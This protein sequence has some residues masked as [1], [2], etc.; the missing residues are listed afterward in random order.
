[1]PIAVKQIN[2][3]ELATFVNS[4]FS[5]Q[6]FSG[7]MLDYVN[8][9]GYLGPHVVYLTGGAQ[10]IF[11]DIVF[12]FSP[13]VP[14]SGETGE[15]VARKYVDDLVN[16]KINDFSGYSTGAFVRA[17]F[18]NTFTA[19][20][21][22]T[23]NIFIPLATN[24]GH[25]ANLQNIL[26]AS[27]VLQSGIDNI[28]IAGTVYEYGTQH[29]TGQKIFDI[30]PLVVIP[31]NPSGA[32]PLS[33]LSG[34]QA[35]N[36]LLLT[37]DQTVSGIKTFLQSPI[38]PIGVDPNSAVR[39][40]QLDALGISMGAI[41]GFAGV[42]SLNG[43]SG[44]SGHLFLEGAGLVSVVQCG[45]VF[46]ISGNTSNT[47]LFYGARIPLPTG[48]TGLQ[49]SFSTGLDYKP[50]IV[51][52]L[53]QSGVSTSIFPNFYN[54]DVTT[55]GFK[56]AFSTGTPI[57]GNYYYNITALQAVSGSGFVG[58][59]GPQ[60]VAG[61]TGQ[62]GPI[63]PTGGWRQKGN[64]AFATNYIY[65]DS[66]FYLGNSYGFTGFFS[67]AGYDPSTGAPW[68]IIASKGDVGGFVNSGVVTGNF[69]NMSFYF[70]EF[71]LSTGLNSVECFI[72]RDFVFTG[73]ALGCITSGTSGFFSGN[74]YQRTPLN[75][76]INF[77]P[78]VINSGMFFTGS[79]N[80]Q[81]TI[82]GMNR[83]GVDILRLSR[84]MTGLSIGIFGMGAF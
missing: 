17:N 62:T 55:G 53:E 15:A 83:V 49:Y 8:K 39:K 26:G 72:A 29:I 82:S 42:L 10:T 56:T 76:K 60:G 32:V 50:I 9:S 46:Y 40:S 27:G 58:I 22:F 69:V 4:T 84:D 52:T 12:A 77:A 38:V 45:Q 75:T 28:S 61:A 71:N 18:T 6:A 66:V 43:T 80:F 30:S 25:G 64:F 41:S 67:G 11:T 36:S 24:T 1:M 70:D 81:N 54:Y 16:L 34:I 20:N 14:Y 68:G 13:S 31:T 21:T 78:I 2:Q 3:T 57:V 48:I 59:V 73:F 51:G 47:S 19:F 63:G 5:G 79:G 44:V 35:L 23:Q 74:L 37:G 65:N 7:T 33:M